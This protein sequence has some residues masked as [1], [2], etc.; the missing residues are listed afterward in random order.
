MANLTDKEAKTL[1]QL[2]QKI[3]E[4]YDKKKELSLKLAERYPEGAQGFFKLTEG[5][6]KPW[7]RVTFLDN[8]QPFSAGTT[9]Y[10]Q[11]AFNRFDIKVETLKNEPKELVA[12]NEKK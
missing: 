3:S 8:L 2:D 4:L 1:F 5:N 12:L 6:E 10:R 11:A 9:Q 7:V